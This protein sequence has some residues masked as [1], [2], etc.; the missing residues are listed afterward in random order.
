MLAEVDKQ[1]EDPDNPLSHRIEVGPV[2]CR[3]LF[4]RLQYRAREAVLRWARLR[5]LPLHRLQYGL[6]RCSRWRH[7]RIIPLYRW[8]GGRIGCNRLGGRLHRGHEG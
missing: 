4:G 7:C 8:R 5:L 3:L 1:I 2:K 6:R